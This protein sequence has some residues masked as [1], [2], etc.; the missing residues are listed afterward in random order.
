MLNFL[1]E[2]SHHSVAAAIATLLLPASQADTNVY[3]PM[4]GYCENFLG[5]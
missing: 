4:L 1:S 3:L 5:G 2:E